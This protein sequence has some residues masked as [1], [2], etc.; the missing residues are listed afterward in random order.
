MATEHD[1]ADGVQLLHTPGWKTLQ[2]ILESSGEHPPAVRRGQKRG[3]VVLDAIDV[4]EE[5]SGPETGGSGSTSSEEDQARS[6]SFLE[7]ASSLGPGALLRA[8]AR[9]EDSDG[10]RLAKRVKKVNL[11]DD[12]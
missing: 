3:S 6:F 2:T 1:I 9:R 10:V 8:K 12:S 5:P 11:D 7:K 4:D